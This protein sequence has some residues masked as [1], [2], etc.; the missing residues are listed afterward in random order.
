MTIQ[1]AVELVQVIGHTSRHFLGVTGERELASSQGGIDRVATDFDFV[2]NGEG[3]FSCLAP[4]ADA[5]KVRHARLMYS[6]ERVSTLMASP[7][8]TKS[9]TCSTSPVSR[10]ADLVAPDTRS[11]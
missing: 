6:P 1:K 7:V 11:P 4:A 8:S 3:V 2:Q 10:V 9:G 5:S